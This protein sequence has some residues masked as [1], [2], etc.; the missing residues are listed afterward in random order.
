MSNRS[1]TGADGERLAID[2]L[3]SKGF[4]ILKTNWTYNKAE[5][6]IIAAHNNYVVFVEVKTRSSDSF[7]EPEDFVNDAKQKMLSYAAE[8]YIF[9]N[10]YEGEIRFDIVAVSMSPDGVAEIRHIEDAFW[11]Y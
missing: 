11:N 2:H 3:C 7:G 6:D 10:R 5:I 1:F 8:G 9:Q 4:K